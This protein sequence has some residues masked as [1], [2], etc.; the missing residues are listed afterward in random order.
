MI[1][2]GIFRRRAVFGRMAFAVV[3]A[4]L[5]L[6]RPPSSHADD[7]AKAQITSAPTANTKLAE[8]TGVC[9]LVGPWLV[10]QLTIRSSDGTTEELSA[11]PP[12][13]WSAIF[14]E[15]TLTLRIG[16]EVLAD[17]SYTS[18]SSRKPY[19]IDAE[20][21]DG[22]MLGIYDG[23]GDT[24]AIRLND[25]ARG[26]PDGIGNF[27]KDRRSGMV[28]ELR[29]FPELPLFVM[30]ADG[31]E[32]HRILAMPGFTSNGSPDWSHDGSRIAIDATRTILG[33]SWTTSHVFVVNADGSSPKDLGTGAMPS[34]SP[35]DKQL[36]YS[37]Y[38]PEQRVWVMN[39]DGMARRQISQNGWG[40][41]WSPK[42]N[43]IAY[44]SGGGANIC[45]YDLDS[46]QR[47][48]LLDRQYKQIY[49]GFTWSPDGKWICFKA[50]LSPSGSEVAA[51]AVEGEKK[52]FKVILPCSAQPESGNVSKTMAWG[53]TGNQIL[54]T[55]QR[56]SDRV[57]QLYILDF[58]GVEPPRLFPGF[59]RDWMSDDMAWSP[60][61]KKVVFTAC[62]PAN[63]E[64]LISTALPA[65]SV[66]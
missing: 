3:A 27:F 13:P 29:R 33:E 26:R 60:D 8:A 11:Q 58:A 32:L 1:G 59:P 66:Q 17:L 23:S 51:V 10:Q 43:E 62:P 20:S 15:K 55:M 56:K 48:T 38:A 61:G 40:S 65:A 28:L 2:V 37:Q 52:G 25:K 39:A 12:R 14:T 41:Q 9:P 45:V 53:G 18:D 49:E 19:T 46:E 7:D 44:V 6:S 30:G 21:A 36:T 57:L 22:A 35:D 5:V 4:S 50:D 34:W 54:V 24:M 16:T 31:S 42:R 63:P 47:H 64:Q